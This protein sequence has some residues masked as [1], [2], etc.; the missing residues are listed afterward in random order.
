[1]TGEKGSVTYI[2]L[3]VVTLKQYSPPDSIPT[4][5]N[6]VFFKYAS[7]SMSKPFANDVCI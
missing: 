5:M 1:M 3:E 2:S 7:H 4:G 6:F